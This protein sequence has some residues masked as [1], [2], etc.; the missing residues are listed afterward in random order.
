[1][2]EIKC[3]SQIDSTVKI[4]GSK[5]ISHRAVIAAGL[6][7]GESFLEGFL[8]CEDTLYTINAL[9]ELGVKIS[10]D[11]E[12]VKVSG[13]GGE[14]PSSKGEKEIF[15]GNSG[16]SYR[17]LLSTVALARG[18]FLLFGSPRLQERPIAD[19]LRALKLLG[20]NASCTEKDGFPP[21]LVH[22]NGINGGKVSISGDISSQYVSSLLL[23]APYAKDDVEI[24]VKGRLV[25]GPYVDLT[26]D[27]MKGFGVSAAREG[28]NHFKVTSG[29]RY[30]PCRFNIEGDVSG[31]SYFWAA[32]AVTGGIVTT[33]NIQARMTHQGDIRFL[34]VLEG[35][36]CHV[37]RGG[38]RVIVR[39]GPLSGVDV[40]MSLVPDLVPTLAAI[41]L[42]ADGKT[43]IHNVPHLRYKESDRLRS[44][45]LEWKR[46][47]GQVEELKDGLI[48]Y[49]GRPLSGT[50][51]EPHNDHRMAMSLAVVGLRVPGI[52]VKGEGCVNKSFPGFWELWGRL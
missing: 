10:I 8:V 35:M 33:K 4:P 49:G 27:V 14:F 38:D 40:D 28:Y 6:A 7:K 12:K 23:A 24:E 11:R 30:R 52:K 36:G 18:N 17:L 43:V 50:V 16:T 5:S 21:V 2:I 26:L 15:L 19:L 25:S 42:F 9:R 47:G 46:L 1:M 44:I 22:A 37:E 32:A 41:A 3:R 51:V 20:V 13:G 48:I 39:G 31:A 34:D 29:E 45:S